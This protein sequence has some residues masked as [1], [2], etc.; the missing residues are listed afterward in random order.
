MTYAEFG[1]IVKNVLLDQEEINLWEMC[2]DELGLKNLEEENCDPR[3][4][5]C[6]KCWEK[7][8]DKIEEG[9]K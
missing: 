1:E 5:S 6:S 4:K 2:P 9:E 8:L 7:A 3:N